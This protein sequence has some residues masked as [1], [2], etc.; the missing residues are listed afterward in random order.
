[1]TTRSDPPESHVSKRRARRIA[2]GIFYSAVVL[3]IVVLTAQITI[4]VH[5]S[6]PA[7]AAGGCKA[8]LVALARSVDSARAASERVEASPEEA[9]AGFRAALSPAWEGR[10]AVVAACKKDPDSR[11][12]A[13]F[14]TIE[15]L[16]Y[17]EEN[18]V[19]R[20]AR[21]LGPLRRQMRELYSGP[22]SEASTK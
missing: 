4:Q 10:D 14:D 5:A 18:A 12:I 2:Y 16:R 6:S 1:M 19:R 8:G 15:R 7:P 11:L 13:A 22:L 20:D 3:F 21:D 9:L 17:A